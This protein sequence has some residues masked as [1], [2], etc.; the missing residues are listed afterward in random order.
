MP[1]VVD[2]VQIPV[3]AAGGICDGRGLAA[4]RMLGAEAVQMGTRFI[5][6]KESIVHQNFKEKVIKAKDIDSEVTGTSTGHPVRQIR[7]QMSREYLRLE[8]EGAGLEELEQLTLGS[9]RRAVM[10]GDTVTG[11]LMA[12][13]IAGLVKKEQSCKEIIEEI[14]QEA[15]ILF[16]K[17]GN[18]TE[19]A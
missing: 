7:N 12:G 13:Q 2:A 19:K 4:A 18:E 11:T 1:Q 9:L 10:D 5:V 15:G 6:A 8:K 14:M 16:A 3:I 17:A